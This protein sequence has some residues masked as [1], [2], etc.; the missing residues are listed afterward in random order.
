MSELAAKKSDPALKRIVASIHYKTRMSYVVI[1]LL[2]MIAAV[3]VKIFLLEVYQVKLGSMEET[4][5][6]DAMVLVTK[7]GLPLKQNQ[8]AL[9]K[10]PVE[11]DMV[12][13]KRCIGLPGD[14]LQ[15]KEGEVIVN[16]LTLA[17]K[18][19]V[20]NLYKVTLNHNGSTIDLVDS[21]VRAG[22]KV[23]SFDY[24]S[25]LVVE[26]NSTRKNE[27]WD[28]GLA[29]EITFIPST[30]KRVYPQNESFQWTKSDFGPVLIPFQGLEV[31]L[32]HE[33]IA[34]YRAVIE[35]FER[36]II[37]EQDGI[38]YIDGE[39][40]STY[41]FKGNYYFFAGDNRSMSNDSRAWGFVPVDYIIGKARLVLSPGIR[42]IN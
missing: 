7:L 18:P 1:V 39:R 4:I 30:N 29:G 40:Q 26:L 32:N 25:T 35:G 12:L 13:I 5:K 14:T 3:L 21:L 24:K 38:Y 28:S 6:T 15:F 17:E 27:L 20:K 16:R 19:S 36:S 9:F 8:V 37:D 23:I 11:T 22:Y 10:S 42:R 2:C 41:R 34:L 33:T 31:V